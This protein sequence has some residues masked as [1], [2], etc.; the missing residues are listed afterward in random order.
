MDLLLTLI[1]F[2]LNSPVALYGVLFIV[3][4]LSAIG[5]P[6]PE[7]AVLVLGGYL[8]YLEFIDVR[9]VI[10]VLAAGIIAADI[11]G[12]M[13]GRFAGHWL[14]DNIFSRISMTRKFT[15]KGQRAFGHFGEKV[16]IL[17]RP[18]LGVRVAVPLLAG[19]FQMNLWKFVAYDITATLPW[20]IFVVSASYYLGSGFSLIFNAMHRVRHIIFIVLLVSIAAYILVR[21]WKHY[22]LQKMNKK[23]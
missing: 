9:I 20:T 21:I 16:V 1:L 15:E 7:E 6:I 14:Y 11:S 10:G 19:H 5:L 18:M 13:M 4:V 3:L 12:Y 17:S 8:A 23:I 2:P 22:Q